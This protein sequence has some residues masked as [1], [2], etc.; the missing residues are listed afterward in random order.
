[1]IRFRQGFYA[2]VRVEDR[3]TTSIRYRNGSLEESRSSSVRKAFI[4]VFDGK[5]WY[6]AST[7]KTDDIQ[8]ELD[9]L[10][11]AATP[12]Y[13]VYEHPAISRLEGQKEGERH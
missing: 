4:R 3:F 8:G 5:M 2:D 1:M 13:S 6:Y 11:G 9:R 12:D 10:Y 7:C